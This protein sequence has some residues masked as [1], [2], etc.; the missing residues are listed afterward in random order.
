MTPSTSQ[1]DGTPIKVHKHTS[2]VPYDRHTY[3]IQSPD[4]GSIT[5][6]NYDDV[7]RYWNYQRPQNAVVIINDVQTVPN[8]S[9][10]SKGKSTAK[11]FN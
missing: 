5:L 4:G 9:V 7:K 2:D 6:D 1:Q 8:N 3:T 11:G 10:K